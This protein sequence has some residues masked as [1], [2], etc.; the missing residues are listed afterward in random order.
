MIIVFKKGVTEIE[1]FLMYFKNLSLDIFQTELDNQIIIKL[2]GNTFMVDDNFLASFK[3][4]EKVIRLDKTYDL[5]KYKGEYL[6]IKIKDISIGNDSKFCL[7]AGPCAIDSYDSLLE[8]TTNMNRVD[9]IRGG[10]FK[11][12]KSP[13]SF[14]G[15][16]LEGIKILNQV[17]K[18][19]NHLVIS[20]IINESDLK[21]FEEN[22]DIIQVGA[23]NMDNYQLLKV[24]GKSSK[25]ILLKRGL[26]ASIEEW[27]LAAEYIVKNGNKNVILC[28][29][30]IRTFETSTRNTLDLSA[31][32]L[33]KKLS[34]LPIVVDPSHATG[35]YDLVEQM[36]LAA[37][38]AGADGIVLEV[39]QDV[40]GLKSDGSQTISCKRYNNLLTK[41]KKVC[42]AVERDF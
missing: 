15:L 21:Y 34:N 7:I 42:E 41:I 26:S 36:T 4:I 6:N 28:E 25:P 12:R 9:V 32:S 27:L 2:V 19:T 35:R 39:S 17:G 1:Q 8:T 5:V 38:A 22:V 31:V 14:Q 10:A 33:I 29:R 24:L 37:I 23:R 40:E 13:Y 3:D 20:E 16:G 18:K 11:P 30:G